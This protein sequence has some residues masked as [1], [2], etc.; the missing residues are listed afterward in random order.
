MTSQVS[1]N[2]STSQSQMRNRAQAAPSR[3]AIPLPLSKPRASKAQS[4]PTFDAKSQDPS[5]RGEATPVVKDASPAASGAQSNVS[6]STSNKNSQAERVSQEADEDVR[7]PTAG[8]RDFVDND[9]KL[10]PNGNTPDQSQDGHIQSS[11][12]KPL[13]AQSARKPTQIRTELPPAFVPSTGQHT[14]QS[15]SS[16]R[17]VNRN[18]QPILPNQHLSRP[19]TGHIV[20]GDVDSSDSSPVPPYSAGSTFLPPPQSVQKPFQSPFTPVQHA[21][22]FS[23]PQAYPMFPPGY[24]PQQPWNPQRGYYAGHQLPSFTHHAQPQYRYP[25]H[26]Q[27]GLTEGVQ[28]S[29]PPPLS[30]P[31]SPGSV[32]AEAPRA[33]QDMRLPTTG[34]KAAGSK[35]FPE[36]KPAF[37]NQLPLRQ[38][39][40]SRQFPPQHQAIP[41][42][43]LR[44]DMDNAQMLRDH[45]RSQFAK[46]PFAD[47]S[48]QISHDQDASTQRIDAHRLILARSPTLLRLIQE[49]V[50]SSTP[51]A[52]L[53][54][55]LPGEYLS[56][57]AFNESLKYIYGGQLPPLEPPHRQSVP[58]IEPVT[59][60]IERM[61]QALQ[62]VATGAWLEMPAIA[63]RGMN[64]A[65]NTMTWDTLPFALKFGLEGGISPM[66]TLDDGSEERDSTTSSDDSQSRPE[67]AS[68]KPTYDPFA[69]ALLQAIFQFVTTNFPPDFYPDTSAPQL[70]ASPRLPILP[71]Q[72]QQQQKHE[73]NKSSRSADP[74]LSQIRFGELPT[75]GSS[76]PSPVTTMISS[77]LFSLPFQ[78]LKFLLEHPVL[79]ERMGSETVGSIIRQTV[80]ER[81]NRRSRCLKVA[82]PAMI[83]TDGEKDGCATLYWEESVEVTGQ[84]RLGLR[85]CRRRRGVDTPPSST[86]GAAN[87]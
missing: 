5:K 65:T 77:L 60:Q 76:R 87:A 26:D 1:T 82:K 16:S 31:G 4:R 47:C 11:Q 6:L 13:N 63:W 64:V 71:P 36:F 19:S 18:S 85:L 7:P 72:Q 40:L 84:G 69:T 23:E 37:P 62:R 8:A 43:D 55:H 50:G 30:R 79:V 20:F 27:S 80:M 67:I 15:S 49:S 41:P 10:S 21:Y 51:T 75:E 39:P 46:P 9:G 14:P 86:E 29:I 59:A 83:G 58:F 57:H 74:R 52:Q 54:M 3:V 45:V 48:L 70:E 38:P 78:L 33:G 12:A 61:E 68:T 73:R 28:A 66:W 44:L 81:E 32:Y 42:P 2:G 34:D 35:P 56:L 53:D 25:P 22:H 24:A 17:H